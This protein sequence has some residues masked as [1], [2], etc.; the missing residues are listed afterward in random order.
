[1]ARSSPSRW[2]TATSRAATAAA[3]QPVPGPGE[4]PVGLLVG[5]EGGGVVVDGGGLDQAPV[6]QGQEV[7][8]AHQDRRLQRAMTGQ[9]CLRK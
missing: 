5:L 8:A 6:G 1:V 4:Q 7:V 2:V 3:S 9:P